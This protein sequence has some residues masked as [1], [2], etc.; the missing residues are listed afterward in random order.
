MPILNSE[1]KRA[2]FAVWLPLPFF[3]AAVIEKSFTTDAR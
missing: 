2:R 3:V 1:R